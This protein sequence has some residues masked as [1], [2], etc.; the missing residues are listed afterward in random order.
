MLD[1]TFLGS[2]ELSF[3]IAL[4]LTIASKIIL[5]IE[6]QSGLLYRIKD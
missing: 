1:F 4:A 5:S 6:T 2:S 3:E